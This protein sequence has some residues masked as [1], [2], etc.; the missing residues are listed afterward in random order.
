MDAPFPLTSPWWVAGV[1]VLLVL[2][3]AAPRWGGWLLLALV[4]VLLTQAQTQ[5]ILS[6]GE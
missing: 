4:A 3:E 2:L 5:G 1:V 6:G